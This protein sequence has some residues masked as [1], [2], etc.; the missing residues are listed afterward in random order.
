MGSEKAMVVFRGQK[1]RRRWLDDEWWY[2][3]IDIISILSESKNPR[4]Y[5]KVLKYRLKKEGSE[6]VTN[7]NQLKLP[8][9]DGK[10]YKTD[11]ATTETIFRIIQ[12]IPSKKAEP[13]KQWLAK[14]GQERIQEIDDPE[15]TMHRMKDTYRAKGYSEE[16]IEKR[17]REIA[18]RNELTDEW[19]RRNVS[20]GKEY[21]ILTAD[22]HNCWRCQEEP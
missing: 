5:W 3:V 1:I 16:W 6:V 20:R 17:F 18:V 7:C 22:M 9:T 11:C 12:S 21:S 4:S 19:D 10:F 14:V 15:L 13:F 2:S 8:S